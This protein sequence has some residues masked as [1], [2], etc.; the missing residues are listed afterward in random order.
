MWAVGFRVLWRWES[1]PLWCV[2]QVSA[3][4]RVDAPPAGDPA[5]LK[6]IPNLFYAP[7]MAR[8]VQKNYLSIIVL[9][10]PCLPHVPKAAYKCTQVRGSGGQNLRGTFA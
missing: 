9:F 7:E 10:A 8:Y 5:K 3:K 2:L 6:S 4:L 1:L